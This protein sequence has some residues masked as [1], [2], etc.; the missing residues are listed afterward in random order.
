MEGRK[1]NDWEEQE[2]EEQEREQEQEQEEH[3]ER[4][5]LLDKHLHEITSDLPC[6]S[7]VC[8]MTHTDS[9]TYIETSKQ[10]KTHV[11]ILYMAG[12]LTWNVSIC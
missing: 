3:E 1:E 4:W 5:Q 6:G 2:Q 9:Y 11:Q 12:G 8:S 10:L 7:S